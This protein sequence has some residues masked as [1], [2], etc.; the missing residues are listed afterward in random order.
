M[1]SGFRAFLR[2]RVS[3]FILRTG[4][5]RF[6]TFGNG[7]S[8]QNAGIVR[9]AGAEDGGKAEA[10]K[11]KKRCKPARGYARNGSFPLSLSDH[12]FSPFCGSFSFT[13]ILKHFLRKSKKNRS[14]SLFFCRR[15]GRPLLFPRPGRALRSRKRSH[16][17]NNRATTICTKN[18]IFLN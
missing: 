14:L 15:S 4:K 18:E 11:Q 17:K 12:R 7:R 3:A 2:E 5:C 9:S 6:L 13:R 16:E 1:S 8:R 10:D